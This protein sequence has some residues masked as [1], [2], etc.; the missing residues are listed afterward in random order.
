MAAKRTNWFAVGPDGR[1]SLGQELV[2][3]IGGILLLLVCIIISPLLFIL[4]ERKHAAERN[5]YRRKR[6]LVALNDVLKFADSGV[7]M[8]LVEFC[9]PGV[10][11][12]T[13]WILSEKTELLKRSLPAVNKDQMLDLIKRRFSSSS[14]PEYAEILNS[15]ANS[16]Q[17][18]DVRPSF[19]NR[20]KK[21]TL[22]DARMVDEEF[23]RGF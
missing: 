19:W 4:G 23:T 6:R 13:W 3:G 20:R 10:F 21:G 22:P 5:S 11:G 17:L 1:L 18:V 16:A 15:L 2:A 14:E 9:T 12:R 8:L 7:G